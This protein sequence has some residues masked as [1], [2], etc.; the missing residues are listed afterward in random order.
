MPRAKVASAEGWPDYVASLP[1]YTP[2][3][4]SHGHKQTI[5]AIA[6]DAGMAPDTVVWLTLRLQEV[7]GVVRVGAAGQEAQPTPQGELEQVRRLREAA[8][9]VETGLRDLWPAGAARRAAIAEAQRLFHGR[10]GKRQEGGL[11]PLRRTELGVVAYITA[12]SL[13]A[14]ERKLMAATRRGRPALS[15]ARETVDLL[16]IY[17]SRISRDA[18]VLAALAGVVLDAIDVPKAGRSPSALNRY[19]GARLRAKPAT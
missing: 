11:P 13:R 9:A 18:E 3:S 2:V 6:L 10:E 5:A 4:L 7:A 16:A 1:E 8:E 17:V 12:E 15:V 14:A 19:A